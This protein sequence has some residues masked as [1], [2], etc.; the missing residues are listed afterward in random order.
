[1]G[2]V[3]VIACAA[4]LGAGLVAARLWAF[5]SARLGDGGFWRQ[6]AVVSRLLLSA[7]E[8]KPFFQEY[9]RLWPVL[10]AFVGRQLVV[11]LAAAMPVV[12]AFACMTL[13]AGGPG[14]SHAA[15]DWEFGFVAAVCVAAVL[16]MVVVKCKS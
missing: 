13:L 9:L 4:G 12:L 10:I 7:D 2:F 8:E 11:A 14:D 16:G 3:E 5:A 6:L 15:S 1:M